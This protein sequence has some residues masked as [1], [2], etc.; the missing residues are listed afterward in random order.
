MHTY[1]CNFCTA[2]STILIFFSHVNF[3]SPLLTFLLSSAFQPAQ[4]ASYLSPS[5]LPVPKPLLPTFVL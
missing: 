4:V 5:L 2:V 3:P 1:K